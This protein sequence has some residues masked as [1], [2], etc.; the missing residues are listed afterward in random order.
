VAEGVEEIEQLTFLNALGCRNIQGFL[1]SKPLCKA[2]LFSVD[3]Q[4]WQMKMQTG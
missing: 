3:Q 1:F 2:D 4:S